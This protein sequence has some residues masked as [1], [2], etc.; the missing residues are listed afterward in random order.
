MRSGRSFLAHRAHI[1]AFSIITPK[2]L[3]N[4]MRDKTALGRRFDMWHT[5]RTLG[6]GNKKP[7]EIAD[8][9][10]TGQALRL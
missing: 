2:S 5:L 3:D 9:V 7:A 8:E 4:L 6:D 10:A 1:S